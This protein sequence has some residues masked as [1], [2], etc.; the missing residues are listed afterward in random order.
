M[1]YFRQGL[2]SILGILATA[3]AVYGGMRVAFT[4][5]VADAAFYL[6][7]VAGMMAMGFMYRRWNGPLIFTRD[8]ISV[9]SLSRFALGGGVVL[10]PLNV[11][12]A[13]AEGGPIP[14]VF[15][16]AP[17][18]QRTSGSPRLSRSVRCPSM[19]DARRVLCS[20]QHAHRHSSHRE[21]IGRVATALAVTYPAKSSNARPELLHAQGPTEEAFTFRHA[22]LPPDAPHPGAPS[23]CGDK[24][25]AT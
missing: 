3:F 23:G 18:R 10:G 14:V 17:D 1:R 16:A 7:A 15:V 4:T 13:F 9:G 22:F 5:A 19:Q 24:C 2:L 8:G 11:S 21:L 25:P 6:V 20:L 12:S